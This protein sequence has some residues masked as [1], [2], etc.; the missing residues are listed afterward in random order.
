MTFSRVLCAGTMAV[1]V[2]IPAAKAQLGEMPR[3][4]GVGGPPD[5]PPP[6]PAQP[7]DPIRATIDA[8]RPERPEGP[9][10]AYYPYFLG[11]DFERAGGR[12]RPGGFG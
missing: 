7:A 1:L 10:P 8:L 3:T 6:A 2:S 12:G 4:G 11:P 5:G 9:I